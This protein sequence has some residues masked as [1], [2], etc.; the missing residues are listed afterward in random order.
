MNFKSNIKVVDS[1]QK[2]TKIEILIAEIYSNLVDIEDELSIETNSF[3]VNFLKLKLTNNQVNFNFQDGSSFL[4]PSLI[5]NFTQ[6][7]LKNEFITI[8]VSFKKIK[9]SPNSF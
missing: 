9:F 3:F 1:E 2:S 6:N 8:K 4:L 5:S 7:C